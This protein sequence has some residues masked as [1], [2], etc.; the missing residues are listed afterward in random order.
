MKSDQM[1]AFAAVLISGVILFGWSHFFGPKPQEQA[2]EIVNS[3]APETVKTNTNPEQSNAQM[4]ANPAPSQQQTQA[5][6]KPV[7]KNIV[8][9]NGEAKV[10]LNNK[11]NIT[12][13][14][15]TLSTEKFSMVA[16]TEQN[17][18]FLVDNQSNF[19]ELF[20]DFS[21][22]TDSSATGFDPRNNVSIKLVLLEDGTLSYALSTQDPRK[23]RVQMASEQFNQSGG[24]GFIEGFFS[25]DSSQNQN[26]SRK[27]ILFHKEFEEY[28]IPDTDNGENA[29]KWF[30]VDSFYHL[31]N[32]TFDDRVSMKYQITESG[33][34]GLIKLS[35]NNR[36]SV[37]SGRIVYSKKYY[38]TL[39][40]LGDNLDIALDFGFFSII[41]IPMFKGLQMIH[42]LIP[43]WGIAIILLTLF[44][45]FV[46]FP[47]YFKQMK[48]MNKM[49]QIQPD[50]QRIKEKFGDDPKKQQM[51]TMELF[52][53]AGVN[54]V[55]SCL[56]L[57][58]QMPI[59][60]AFYKVL[61]V[62]AE[63]DNE[64]FFGWIVNLTTKDPYYVLPILVA[65]VMWLNS[66]FMPNTATDPMQKRVMNFLPIIFG[67][68]FINMPAGLNIYILV[69]TLFGIGQQ[70]FVNKRVEA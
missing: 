60:F 19:N 9:K 66:K 51:E 42:G 6:P 26:Y 17:L 59:F 68:I 11:I 30:G 24:K 27:F 67:F 35:T 21:D 56:P 58:L 64:A 47:L 3:T 38:N 14:E 8:L 1:R 2:K 4:A 46:T 57:I 65:A 20:F 13:Y 37:L 53:R 70:I 36:A 45:R 5:T 52:K 61:T 63:L 43:N 41:A 29:V 34:K 33:D 28:M 22:V 39:T 32:V 15:T 69:S 7:L 23:F 12:D 18:S 16:G 10:T 50:I 62:S 31:F 25:A 54:P 49:K 44:I 55:G 48:S 40:R